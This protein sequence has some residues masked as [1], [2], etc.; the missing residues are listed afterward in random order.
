MRITFIT[1]IAAYLLIFVILPFV[2]FHQ[3]AYKLQTANHFGF[4]SNST[5]FL[6]RTLYNPEY[7]IEIKPTIKNFQ[8]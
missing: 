4:K 8:N 1:S 7:R 5:I 3:P 6:S 2:M